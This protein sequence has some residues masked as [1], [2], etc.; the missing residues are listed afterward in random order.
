MPQ[1]PKV[2][3]HGTLIELCT[4]T[5]QGLPFAATPYIRLI[6]LS[7]LARAQSLYPL[8]LC[9]ALLMANH[10]HL[11]V[12]VQDP[13]HVPKFVEYLKRELAHAVNHLLGNTRATVW[14]EGYDSP[15]ILDAEK[16]IERIAYCYGN[17]SEADLAESIDEY[18][19]WSTWADFQSGAPTEISV[20]RIARNDI[21]QLPLKTLSFAEQEDF[22]RALEAKGKE[23]YVLRIEPDAWMQ[24]FSDELAGRTAEQNNKLVVKRIREKEAEAEQTRRGPVVGA[25]ALR[26]QSMRREYRPVKRGKKMLC[27]SSF[28]SRRKRYIGWFKEQLLRIKEAKFLSLP[29]PWRA[30]RPPGF[31]MPGGFLCASVNPAFVP[32]A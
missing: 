4:R 7:I 29:A 24:C 27:L 10:P 20:P 2:F 9:H 15:V 21:P 1:D 28:V 23:H 3:I 31:F 30:V 6:W 16:A 18:P 5:E 32:L 13:A 25:H 14:E 17:C 22:A 8:T 11:L 12:I 19:N 26:L